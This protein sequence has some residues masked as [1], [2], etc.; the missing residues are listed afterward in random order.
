MIY[1]GDYMKLVLLRTLAIVLHAFITVLLVSAGMKYDITASW[2]AFFLYVAGYI[3][4]AGLLLYHL[5]S[6]F[7][8]IKTR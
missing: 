6:F 1:R 8:F 2:L 7:K 3:L 5:I 4:M